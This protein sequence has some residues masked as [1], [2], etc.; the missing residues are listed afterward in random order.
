MRVRLVF[1]LVVWIDMFSSM[2]VGIIQST[3]GLSRTKR[4]REREFVFCAWAGTSITCSQISVLLVLRPSDLN[5]DLSY[6]LSWFLDLDW[7][8]I[9][10]FPGPP[11]CKR[12]IIGLLITPHNNKSLRV[13][14]YLSIGSFLWRTLTYTAGLWGGLWWCVH[15]GIWWSGYQHWCSS[16]KGRAWDEQSR[17]WFQSWLWFQPAVW[18]WSSPATFLPHF[19][20]VVEKWDFLPG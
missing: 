4:Q 13:F 17:P 10:C 20:S 7:N 2:C 9:P 1:K 15:N 16:S 14:L 5:W 8:Q 18:L 12:Q 19:S 3:K 11:A 6:L